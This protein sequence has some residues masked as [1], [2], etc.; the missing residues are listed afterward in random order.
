MKLKIGLAQMR[1]E[2]GDWEGNLRRTEELMSEAASLGCEVVVFPEMGLSGYCYDE[3]YTRAARSLDSDVVRRFVELTARYGV[4]ASGG[5]IEANGDDKPFVTQV[6]AQNGRVV[7]VYHKTHIVD[8]EAGL[9]SPG[10]EMPV[11]RLRVRGK[12]LTCALAICADS[13]RP[14]LFA[15]FAEQGARVVFHSSAPGLYERRTDEASWRAG[16]EW[17][18]GYLGERLPGY[19]VENGLAIAVATQ[20]GA[21]VDEDFPGGSFV[22]GPDGSCLACTEDH[23]EALLVY[24]LDV[25]E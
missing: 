17:Y 16:Y 9:F 1:C 11:F 13:D 21:T 5:F 18:R 10:V 14:D 15:R 8:E 2:K 6:L 19:A 12:E 4:A 24:E 23:R 25:P 20:C 3:H 22:F 7:G